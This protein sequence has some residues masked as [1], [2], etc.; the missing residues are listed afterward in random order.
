MSSD[1]LDHIEIELAQI[2]LTPTQVGQ[3]P[4]LNVN[5]AHRH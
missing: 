2:V 1:S 5:N 3:L 4:A